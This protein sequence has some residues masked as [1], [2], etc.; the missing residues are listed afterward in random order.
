MSLKNWMFTTAFL[1]FLQIESSL[2]TWSSVNENFWHHGQSGDTHASGTHRL[3][4]YIRLPIQHGDGNLL[5]SWKI[6][7]QLSIGTSINETQEVRLKMLF[8]DIRPKAWNDLPF[9]LQKLT[10]YQHFRVNWKL[11]CL[12]TF[13]H[14]MLIITL[15]IDSKTWDTHTTFTYGKPTMHGRSPATIFPT[16]WINSLTV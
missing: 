13:I 12:H 6:C 14:H 8:L 15:L 3:W 2:A 5:R 10:D 16:G 4:S 1:Y 11:I 7:Q 9:S